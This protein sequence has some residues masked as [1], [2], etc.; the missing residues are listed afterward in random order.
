[1]AKA[2]KGEL[3]VT[4]GGFD[5]TPLPAGTVVKVKECT[6]RIRQS[7]KRSIEG[8][9]A[10][11]TELLAVK[12]ALPQLFAPWLRAEFG[13]SERSAYNFMSVAERFK[14]ANFATLPIQLSAAYLLATSSVPDKAREVAMEKAKAGDKITV[15]VAK[16]IVAQARKQKRPKQKKP[17]PAQKLGPQLLK[18]LEG[19]RDRWDPE[20]LDELVEQLRK[21]AD[22]LV[23]AGAASRRRGR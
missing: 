1:M 8:A 19:F 14:G 13:W 18:M 5:Y 17:L 3:V 4:E 12:K 21:F 15:P 20:E 10:V 2:T 16:E 22:S 9:I 7:I 11:G 23:A 6:E